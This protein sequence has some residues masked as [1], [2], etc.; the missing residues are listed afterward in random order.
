MHIIVYLP[1]MHPS[2]VFVLFIHDAICF[3]WFLV[4]IGSEPELDP[5]PF[6]EVRSSAPLNQTL[7]VQTKCIKNLLRDGNVGVYFYFDLLTERQ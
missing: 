2:L 3:T 6:T 7:E 5:N 1:L 4:R